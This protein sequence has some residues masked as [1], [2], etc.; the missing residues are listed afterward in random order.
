MVIYL[1]IIYQKFVFTQTN[2][3]L[4]LQSKGKFKIV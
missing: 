2:N 1:N 4:G 3:I